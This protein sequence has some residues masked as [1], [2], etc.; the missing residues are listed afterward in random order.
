MKYI[1][2]IIGAILCSVPNGCVVE[3]KD[4]YTE[5]IEID[6]AEI[7]SMDS[8]IDFINYVDSTNLVEN[9]NESYIKIRQKNEELKTQLEKIKQ[10]IEVVK[11]DLKVAEKIIGVYVPAD[12]V[13]SDLQSK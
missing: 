12:T 5:T 7:N 1:E 9:I 13:Y 8:M 10:E 3:G 11:H 6:T 4:I 2:A